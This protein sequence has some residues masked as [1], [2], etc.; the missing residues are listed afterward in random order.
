MN[1]TLSKGED[2]TKQPWGDASDL[3]KTLLWVPHDAAK[4]QMEKQQCK[5]KL[6]LLW[7]HI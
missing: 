2:G 5:Y 6:L 4:M 1:S 7:V 3:L